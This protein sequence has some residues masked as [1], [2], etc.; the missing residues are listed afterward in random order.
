MPRHNTRA[1][2][3]IQTRHPQEHAP[4]R[5]ARHPARCRRPPDQKGVQEAGAV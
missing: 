3:T 5:R 2:A 4:L 1:H